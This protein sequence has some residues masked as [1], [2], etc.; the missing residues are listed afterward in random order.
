MWAD[1]SLKFPAKSLTI[2]KASETTKLQYHPL[3]KKLKFLTKSFV[4]RVSGSP[5]GG[6]QLLGRELHP[7]YRL[8]P[9]MEYLYSLQHST[10]NSI[11]G[12]YCYCLYYT[13]RTT[14]SLPMVIAYSRA[15]MAVNNDDI[16]Y[17][18]RGRSNRSNV[19]K[20]IYHHDVTVQL[21]AFVSGLWIL[22]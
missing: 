5:G 9:H 6:L 17:R 21:W 14:F 11:H 2:I 13:R 16:F 4:Y 12:S 10:A 19:S 22:R 15:L 7:A 8:P 1:K 18:R 3:R 20:H